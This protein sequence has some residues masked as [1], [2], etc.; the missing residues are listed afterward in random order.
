MFGTP[1]SKKLWQPFPQFKPRDHPKTVAFRQG[2]IKRQGL[3]KAT[4]MMLTYNNKL[5][6]TLPLET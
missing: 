5:I 1:N 4:I 2:T 6:V 3:K